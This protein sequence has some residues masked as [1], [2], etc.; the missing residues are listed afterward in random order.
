MERGRREREK[1]REKERERERER[2]NKPLTSVVV[3]VST[4]YPLDFIG[5]VASPSANSLLILP[6]GRRVDDDGLLG[7][8]LW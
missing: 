2:E 4:L 6:S 8:L 5:E 3:G 1:E 7:M